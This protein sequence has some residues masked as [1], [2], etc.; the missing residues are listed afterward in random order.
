M[1]R[2]TVE[3]CLSQVQNRFELVALA[4]K[5]GKDISSGSPI[6]V[7]RDNDKNG[8][9]AL[10]E[11]AKKKISIDELRISLYNSIKK[12]RA[13]TFKNNDNA[14]DEQEDLAILE[15]I[16]FD[17]ESEILLDDLE[18]DMEIS[19]FPDEDDEHDAPVKAFKDLGGNGFEGVE[20]SED[21]V[22][23]DD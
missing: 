16:D 11:I 22:D 1:A 17:S 20:F 10:R 13:I 5:R 7:S 2:V 15:E 8:V 23:I 14:D 3:D 19:D 6:H 18:D 9:I 4:A 21:D 12:S